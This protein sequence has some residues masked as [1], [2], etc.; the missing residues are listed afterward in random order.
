MKSKFFFLLVLFL[1]IGAFTYAQ[2]QTE[3]PSDKKDVPAQT[4]TVDK[5]RSGDCPHHQQT[6]AKSECKWVDANNDGICDTCNKKDC[7]DKCKNGSDKKCDPAI[8]QYH[9][10]GAK[11]AGCCHSK[12]S[13]KPK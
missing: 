9:K 12:D 13:K 5:V 8:C 7:S 1:G 11:P 4:T 10:G 2:T 3:T 6:A